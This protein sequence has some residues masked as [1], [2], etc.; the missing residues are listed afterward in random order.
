MSWIER[1]FGLDGVDL[2]VHAGVTACAVGMMSILPGNLGVVLS[3]KMVALSLLLFGWRRHRALKRGRDGEGL[4]L[5]S[6]EMAA[7]R[8]DDV[9]TRL[10][11]LES[12]HARIAELEDRLDF[13]ER[14]LA[15]PEPPPLLAKGNRNG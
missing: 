4:G 3:F 12:T 10:A 6:G 1:H 5:S 7:A 11:E 15:R 9:E 2:S 8:F 13:A 14:Q